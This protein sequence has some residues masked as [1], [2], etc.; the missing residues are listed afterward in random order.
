MASIYGIYCVKVQAGWFGVFLSINLSFFSNDALNYMLQWCD[1]VRESTPFEEHKQPETILEDDLSRECA[2]SSPTDEPEKPYSC[3]S[4]STDS[5]KSSSTDSCKASSTHFCKSSSKPST[6]FITYNQ[7]ES[8]ASKVVKEQ[9]N[10]LDEMKRILNSSSHYEALGFPR[11]K[12][13]DAVVLK[14][15]YRTKVDILPF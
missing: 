4:S 5:C 8:S 12:K 15:E 1:S 9:I 3:K 6:S 14:K 10:S 7:N 11:H 13:I 2:Y